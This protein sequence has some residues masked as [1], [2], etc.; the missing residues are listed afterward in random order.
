[1]EPP[2]PRR[3]RTNASL[4]RGFATGA[5]TFLVAVLLAFPAQQITKT[6]SLGSSIILLAF[7]VGMGIFFDIVGIAVAVADEAPFHAMA[8]KKSRGAKE[9]LRL[10]RNSERV[11]SLC[12]DFIGDICGTVSGALGAAAAFQVVRLKPILNQTMVNVIIV[13][14]VAGLTVGG[15]AAAKGI[16]LND[17]EEIVRRAGLFLSWIETTL[18]F[19][20]LDSKGSVKTK[21]GGR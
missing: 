7:I 1:L 17:S 2:K 21:K 13:G 3:L 14:T 4:R 8:A 12:N 6:L 18:G 19:S 9:G 16:G 5:V 10:L 15:K 20:I 11:T